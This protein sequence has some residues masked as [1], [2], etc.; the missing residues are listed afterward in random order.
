MSSVRAPLVPRS[1]APVRRLACPPTPDSVEPALNQ[2]LPPVSTGALE[3][4][5]VTV[6]SPPLVAELTPTWAE[7]EPADWESPVTA[8][9]KPE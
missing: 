1:L 7:M 9:M 2:R 5:A 4:P 3:R 6:T 8:E